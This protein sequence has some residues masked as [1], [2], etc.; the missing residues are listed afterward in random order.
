MK[1]LLRVNIFVICL[2][3][4]L[5]TKTLSYT[6]KYKG[7]RV[8]AVFGYI[9]ASKPEMRVKEYEMYKAVYCTLCKKLGKEYG[10]ITR[11]ALSYDFTFMALLELSLNEGFDGTCRESCVFN[12]LKKCNY[13]KDDSAFALSSAALVILTYQKLTDDIYDEK[14]IKRLIAKILKML[15]GGAYK[16]AADNFPQVDEIAKNY[17]QQ[18]REAENA[19]NCSLDTA[20]QPSSKMLSSLL[21]MCSEDE[22]NKKV[23]AYLGQ[24]LGRYI[25]LLDCIADRKKDIKNNSFNPLCHLEENEA[26]EKIR[27]Q[28]YIVINEAQKAFELLSVKKFKDI[29]G[30]IIYVGLEDTMNSE[31]IRLEKNK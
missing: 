18:Q 22:K 11:F 16:K 12:P 23:L 5:F 21:P 19:E 3:N 13:C 4:K 20:A 9:R 30:N 14:G 28:L 24:L 2:I 26:N 31:F 1:P 8:K 29:L 17:M 27:T 6:V 25:Y 7:K 15:F 10:F